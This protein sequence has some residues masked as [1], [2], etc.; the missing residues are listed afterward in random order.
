VFAKDLIDDAADDLF[1]L[2][3]RHLKPPAAQAE[4]PLWEICPAM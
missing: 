4:C 1:V 2:F 3:R